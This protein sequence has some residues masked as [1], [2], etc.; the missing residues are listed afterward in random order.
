M[1]EIQKEPLWWK[2][3]IM[4]EPDFW[5]HFRDCLK[6][7]D[8]K[9]SPLALDERCKKHRLLHRKFWH[10]KKAPFARQKAPVLF[11][12]RAVLCLRK[13]NSSPFRCEF[14]FSLS[15]FRQRIR[16]YR[17]LA[18]NRIISSHAFQLLLS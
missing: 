8:R 12:E 10:T 1:R 4:I 9:E 14:S 11:D 6:K 16:R 7:Q 15:F 17:K 5:S 13:I 18:N 2:E 3:R